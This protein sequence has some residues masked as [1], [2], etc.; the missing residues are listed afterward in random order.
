MKK[1]EVILLLSKSGFFNEH[2]DTSKNTAPLK[3]GSPRGDKVVIDEEMTALPGAKEESKTKQPYDK[4]T[5]A[6]KSM[7]IK[8]VDKV[9]TSWR[10]NWFHLNETIKEHEAL[11][12]EKYNDL[13]NKLTASTI[14]PADIEAIAESIVN[15]RLEEYKNN[16]NKK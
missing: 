10:E 6:M 12:S 7:I 8:E 16:D 11:Y 2:T 1:K 4:M 14:R 9:K 5:N 3:H 15:K 13:K